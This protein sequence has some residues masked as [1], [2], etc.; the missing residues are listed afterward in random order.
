MLSDFW[1]RPITMRAGVVLPPGY[2]KDPRRHYAAV[3]QV[4]G[5]GGN[6]T[7]AWR[8]AAGLNQRM[9]EGKQAEMIHVFLDGSFPTGHHEFADSVNN[10]P[11]G[12][13]LTQ[14]FIPHLKNNSGS[15]PNRTPAS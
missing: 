2:A 8:Q 3:Y 9:S 10:G 5:F 6:H 13:A 1:G 11:W 4:H 14:E 12:R 15:L 7:G